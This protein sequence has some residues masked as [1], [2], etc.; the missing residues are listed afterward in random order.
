GD[1]ERASLSASGHRVDYHHGAIEES[2]ENTPEGLE[3][4]FVL[5]AKP[6]RLESGKNS[7]GCTTPLRPRPVT[8]TGAVGAAEARQASDIARDSSAWVHLDL[9]LWGDLLPR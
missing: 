9:A 2:Y 1:V 5:S 4:R 8:L 3:Q 7:T 6:G